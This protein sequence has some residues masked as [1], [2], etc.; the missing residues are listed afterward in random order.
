[1]RVLTVINFKILL[2]SFCFFPLSVCFSQT[3]EPKYSF[4]VTLDA[5]HGGNDYGAPGVFSNEK[6]INLALVLKLGALIEKNSKDVKVVYT[7]TTDEFIPLMERTNIANRNKANLF[8]SLHCNSSPRKAAAG[9]ET[10]VL[11]DNKQRTKANLEVAKRENE[12][13]YLEKDYQTT[14]EGFDPSS[15]ESVIGITIMQNVN[16]DNSVKL[17]SCVEN[18]FKD[19]GRFS[20]GVKQSGFFVLAFTAMP[21]ILIE[22]GFISNPDDEAYLNSEEGQNTIANDIYQAFLK[23]KKEYDKKSGK[24]TDTEEKPVQPDVVVAKPLVDT[25]L[26]VQFLTSVYKYSPNAVQMRGLQNVEIIKENGKYS[27]YSGSTNLTSESDNSLK[28]AQEAGFVTA[29]VVEFKTKDVLPS[30]YYTIELLVTSKRYRE[31]DP[32]FKGLDVTRSK[33]DDDIFTYTTGKAATYDTAEKLLASVK[34]LG[35]TDAVISKITP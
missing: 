18:S 8:I 30:G 1:M 6:D 10:W 15:P 34:R 2:F 19:S 22:N 29:K 17:A 35:I 31:K 9:T 28:V 5:G 12:V 3:S 32:I 23:Y 4:T 24:S 16:I 20:R 27:Y 13:I 26:K 14:Y 21:S 25:E 11:G 7:R 33:S